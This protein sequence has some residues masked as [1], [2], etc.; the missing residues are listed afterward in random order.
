MSPTDSTASP[1]VNGTFLLTCAMTSPPRAR[2]AS[3]AAGSTFTSVPS[4]TVASTGGD[5]CISTTSGGIM[6]ASITGIRESRQGKYL[7]RALP[8]MPG[9]M[10][11][12][13]RIT[14][15]RSGTPGCA[16]S[17][18]SRYSA[19]A[20]SSTA[21]A[22]HGVAKLPPATTRGTPGSAPSTAPSRDRDT[23]RTRSLC[24]TSPWFQDWRSRP[25]RLH[26]RRSRGRCG[27]WRAARVLPGS[28]SREARLPW[29][30]VLFIAG[31]DPR[32]VWRGPPLIGP[33][34]GRVA[35]APCMATVVGFAVPVRTPLLV[36]S[37]KILINYTF[38]NS[39]LIL[40]AID[41]LYRKKPHPRPAE[42]RTSVDQHP[43][44]GPE[45]GDVPLPG[46]PARDGAPDG[47][48]DA[49]PGGP[50]DQVPGGPAAGV[51]GGPAD[52]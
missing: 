9:P 28:A 7:S 12:D 50:G 25:T 31:A 29:L 51:P 39:T 3:M 6:V 35:P 16:F 2:T 36:Y 46:G 27:S 48:G 20:A 19:T 43:F 8:R 49:V 15:S 42:W 10:N 33:L 34:R 47:P 23:M 45:R 24:R 38:L 22:C 13:S 30:A 32:L 41:W 40:S 44:P 37:K 4:D 11:G 1:Y 21:S 5:V 18:H 14:P 17:M 26:S 52:D